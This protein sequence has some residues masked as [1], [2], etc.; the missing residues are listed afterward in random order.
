M[1]T[2]I[3]IILQVVVNKGN[4]KEKLQKL[5]LNIFEVTSVFNIKLSVFWIPRKYKTQADTLSKNMDN[6]DW[7]TTS[8]LMDIIERRRSNITIDR[9]A[10]GKNRKSKRFNSRYLCPETKGVN[11]FSLD[12]SNEFN[13]FVPPAY[14]NK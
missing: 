5:A 6:D 10:S 11:A 13:L 9:F 2:G 4:N 7:V 3:P 12:W 8:N 1:F 14:L